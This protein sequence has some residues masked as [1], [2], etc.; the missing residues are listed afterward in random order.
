MNDIMESDRAEVEEKEKPRLLIATDTFLP[1]AEGISRFLVDVLPRLSEDFNVFVISP[2]YGEVK[3]EGYTLIQLPLSKRSF[4]DYTLPRKD[5]KV[6][7]LQVAKA[8]IIF[9]QTVGPIGATVINEAKKQGKP[10][11]SYI[12]SK[13]W[14]LF[15]KYLNRGALVRKIIESLTLIQM[16]RVYGKANLMIVPSMEMALLLQSN[17][18]KVPSEIV[19]LGVDPYRF[20]PEYNKV[21]AKKNIGIDYE[22]TVIG[23][24]GRISYEKDI[25]TLVRAFLWLKKNNPRVRLLVVG[26]GNKKLEESIRDK[27][28]ITHVKSTPYILPYLNAMDIFV[29]PS[30]T[31]TTS[32]ATLEAMS[33]AIPVIVTPVGAMKDYV[34][35]GENGYIFKKQDWLSLGRL[36]RE[37]TQD[38]ML[39]RK[40][41]EESRKAVLNGYLIKNTAEKLIS[42]LKTLL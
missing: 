3:N 13:D 1:R 24:V 26:S 18:I 20:V 34:K 2:D 31:E 23:Y 21:E 10:A 6:L 7:A 15:S 17:G 8:D 11:A 5:G 37:L 29:M 16:R 28:G 12:H 4:G 9:S 19:R 27:S 33:T 35:D 38:V 42:T 14:E 25:T 32:L 22:D 36:M 30:L 41:G 40:M 39:R